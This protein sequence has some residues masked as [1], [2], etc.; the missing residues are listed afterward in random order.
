MLKS[1]FWA[2]FLACSWTWCIGMFLPVLLVRNWGIWACVVFAVPNIIGAAAM[3]FV[4]RSRE[5]SEDILIKHRVA[6]G[7]FSLITIAFHLYFVYWFVGERLMGPWLLVIPVVAFFLFWGAGR[8]SPQTDPRMAA[9]VWVLSMA[10]FAVFAWQS[11]WKLELPPARWPSYELLWLAPLCVFGFALC[12]YLD[13]TFHRARMAS[14]DGSGM[15]FSLGF[16]VFFLCMILF[17]LWY[18][19]PI[20]AA[21]NPGNSAAIPRTIVLLIGLHMSIQ[22]AFTVAI[23]VRELERMQMP[24]NF[25]LGALAVLVVAVLLAS[26][27][28]KIDLQSRLGIDGGEVGYWVFMGFY[29]ALAPTYV[30]LFMVSGKPIKRPVVVLTVLAILCIPSLW[31]AFIHRQMVLLLPAV[32]ILF[33]SRWVAPRRMMS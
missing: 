21:I 32:A 1:L 27:M 31:I 5:G 12:P 20:A 7:I 11:G 26:G 13:A 3:G 14:G 2:F 22:S 9:I 24:M 18:T 16:G 6:V 10:A 28:S 17:T 25:Q 15:V 30:W 29:T 33:A 23:H 8:Q 4:I 19:R